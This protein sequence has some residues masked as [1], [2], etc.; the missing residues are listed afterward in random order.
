M[1][2]QNPHPAGRADDPV[3]ADRNRAGAN[4]AS[5]LAAG[6]STREPAVEPI[7][8]ARGVR[9]SFPLGRSDSIEILHGIDLDIY[10]GEFVAIVGASGS[11]KST[12]LY[13]LSGIDL[14]TGGT[15]TIAGQDLAQLSVKQLEEFRLNHIGF[16]FQQP[17]LLDGVTLRENAL[18]PA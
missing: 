10:P 16:I 5:E 18:L 6:E 13:A 12:L 7:I 9:K 3:P 8:T 17:Q 15:V 11:G 2:T 14:P 4:P 1:T